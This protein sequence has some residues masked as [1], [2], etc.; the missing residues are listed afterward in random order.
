MFMHMPDDADNGHHGTVNNVPAAHELALTRNKGELARQTAYIPLE[1]AFACVYYASRVTSSLSGLCM[2][3]MS[4]SRAS[5]L[6]SSLTLKHAIPRNNS[7][8]TT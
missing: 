3:V 5:A 7:A 8:L 1:E 6:S 4:A 2:Q